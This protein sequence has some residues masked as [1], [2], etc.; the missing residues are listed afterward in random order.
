MCYFSRQTIRYS[1]LKKKKNMRHAGL[2]FQDEECQAYILKG[3]TL[4]YILLNYKLQI[5]ILLC[6]IIRGTWF[7]G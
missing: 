2:A 6:S 1:H 3:Q 5:A 7:G 4:A